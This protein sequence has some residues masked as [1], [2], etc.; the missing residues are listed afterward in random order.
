MRDFECNFYILYS[1]LTK[2][3]RALRASFRKQQDLLYNCDF[4]VPSV[5]NFYMNTIGKGDHQQDKY[6]FVHATRYFE[7]NF[8][9]L[10]SKLIKIFPLRANLCDF[11]VQIAELVYK[12]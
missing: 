5:H 10:Y 1:K 12:V 3:L 9:I 8:Y 7:L 6:K 4:T 2:F 11:I